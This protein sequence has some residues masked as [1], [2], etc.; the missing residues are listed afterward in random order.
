VSYDYQQGKTTNKVASLPD[1]LKKLAQ[2]LISD[3]FQEEGVAKEQSRPFHGS[4]DYAEHPGG[5]GSY[6]RY[7]RPTGSFVASSHEYRAFTERQRGYK[8]TI[9]IG[10][11]PHRRETIL[12]LGLSDSPSIEEIMQARKRLLYERGEE[13]TIYVRPDA[14][15]QIAMVAGTIMGYDTNHECAELF[16]M[17]FRKALAN[18]L[19]ARV[20]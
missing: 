17:K 14:F 3:K 7:N 4:L 20:R 9:H 5:F 13:I 12:Q 16:G 18:Y 11:D 6:V 8:E 15:N 2:E 1:D 10:H 19:Q